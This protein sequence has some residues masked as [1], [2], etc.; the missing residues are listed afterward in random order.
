MTNNDTDTPQAAPGC[1]VIIPPTRLKDKALVPGN[2]FGSDREAIRLAEEAL[3]ELSVNFKDWIS[4]DIDK[5]RQAHRLAEGSAFAE[6]G[7]DA[8]FNAAHDLKGQAGTFGYPIAGD[9][10]NS[11]CQL[12][13][14]LPDKR[15]IPPLLIKQHV[16]AVAAIVR[17]EITDQDHPVA[18]AV[19]KKLR[20][21]AIDFQTRELK[22]FRDQN[23]EAQESAGDSSASL[24]S[25]GANY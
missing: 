5:L 1:T 23:P 25:S 21:V 8:L 11:L 3:E 9:I 10:C 15:R 18:R 17:E 19:F 16:D 4:T 24:K 7:V 22:R 13:D 12:I 20:E 2:D 6:A 14:G